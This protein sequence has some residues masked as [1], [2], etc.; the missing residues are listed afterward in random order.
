M[1]ITPIGAQNSLALPFLRKKQTAALIIQH[2]KPDGQ[3]EVSHGQDDDDAGIL[4]A[5][6]D[7]CKALES[8]DYHAVAAALKAAFELLEAAP[9]A[10]NESEESE[11]E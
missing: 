10:E 8:K 9:H 1:E 7:L 2:R 11:E 3:V 6:E 4:A 5:A